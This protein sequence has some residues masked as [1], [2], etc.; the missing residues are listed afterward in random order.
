VQQESKCSNRQ[1]VATTWYNDGENSYKLV[2]IR[3]RVRIRSNIDP[4]LPWK[5]DTC[6]TAVRSHE[7]AI[8]R[9]LFRHE[10]RERT[11]RVLNTV[12]HTKSEE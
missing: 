6:S 2:I 11:I 8:Y 9:D 4:K 7:P 5:C 12:W 1:T 10:S 3:E